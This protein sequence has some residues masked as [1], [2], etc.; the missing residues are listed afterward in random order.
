MR[1]RIAHVEF[2]PLDY[3]DDRDRSGLAEKLRAERR[4]DRPQVFGEQPV[5]VGRGTV[6]ASLPIGTFA[7][8]FARGESDPTRERAHLFEMIRSVNTTASNF[9]L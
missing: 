5:L 6:S 2:S 3:L 7:W 8:S 1:L 9:R 4:V